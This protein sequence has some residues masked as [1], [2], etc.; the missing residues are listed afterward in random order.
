MHINCLRICDISAFMTRKVPT[1]LQ[2][3]NAVIK[4]GVPQGKE[5][6]NYKKNASVCVRVCVCVSNK[7]RKSAKWKPEE[8]NAKQLSICHY[9]GVR[10]LVLR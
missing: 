9:V 2:K 10:V 5:G 1:N 3:R 4:K 7:K 8:N 6:K